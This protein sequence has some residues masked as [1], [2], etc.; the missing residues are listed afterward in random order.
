MLTL[1]I[2]A[3]HLYT[4]FD[5]YKAQNSEDRGFRIALAFFPVVGPVIYL[6][7]KKTSDQPKK[8]RKFMENRQFP[9]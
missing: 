5:A 6:L 4:I 8:K 3:L 7:T 1:I 2:V 9:S